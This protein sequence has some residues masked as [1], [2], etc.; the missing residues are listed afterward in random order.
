VNSTADHTKFRRARPKSPPSPPSGAEPARPTLLWIGLWGLLAVALGDPAAA[1]AQST[2]RSDEG[3][4]SS[5]E[6]PDGEASPSP[7]DPTGRILWLFRDRNISPE[8]KSDF[9]EALAETLSESNR[10][11]LLTPGEFRRHVRETPAPVPS[12]FEGTERCVSPQALVLAQLDLDA[13]VRVR[14]RSVDAGLEVDYRFVDRRGTATESARLSGK[15]AESLAFSLVRE[16]FDATG[17]VEVR[18]TPS[19]ATVRIDGESMGKT[20]FRARLPV[21]A[22]RFELRHPDRRTAR[23]AFDLS[24]DGTVRIDRELPRKPGRLVLENTPDS[25]TIFIGGEPRGRPGDPI[26]L[27]PGTYAIAVRADGYET[28]EENLEIEAGET[29]RRSVPMERDSPLLGEVPADAIAV[30]RY[31]ARVTLDQAI[32]PTSFRDARGSAGGTDYELEGF[33]RGGS[34]GESA[35]ETFAPRGLRIDFGY[36]GR[37]FGVLGLSLSYTATNI[38]E[39]ATFET[40]DDRERIGRVTGLRR[41]Q[42][43]PLQLTYRRFF[44]NFV[45]SVELGTGISFQ[46]LT[47]EDL[48]PERDSSV[49]FSQTEAFW[50][51]GL[52]GQY[53]FNSNWFG[54]LRYSFQDYFNSGRGVEHVISIGA[55]AAY[56]D[57]F[58]FAPEPPEEL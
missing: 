17:S 15:D 43:R 3:E 47:V 27:Q 45:P 13:V 18:S 21:G 20:P 51:L 6:E 24:S 46:W 23:G 1:A 57:I 22:H 5:A 30:N 50:N 41:L 48:E 36:T 12:C 11:H 29:L 35:K 38:D 10:R 40:S 31:I 34:D 49:L 55:G 32:H 25:A 39:R 53:F 16:L 28:F 37:H 42:L 56:P 26:E 4:T 9:R 58:G 52:A 2:S 8:Q 7:S 33:A 14:L 44:K 19:G 54:F